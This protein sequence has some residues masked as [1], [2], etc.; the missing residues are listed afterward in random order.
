M[1]IQGQRC[2]KDEME[3]QNVFVRASGHLFYFLCLN[4]TPTLPCVARHLLKLCLYS[5]SLY[6]NIFTECI[7]ILQLSMPSTIFPQP[8]CTLCKSKGTLGPRYSHGPGPSPTGIITKT[9]S[10]CAFS[11]IKCS[12]FCACPALHLSNAPSLC[13]CSPLRL[14]VPAFNLCCCV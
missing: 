12:S 13:F 1:Y 2:L 4:P 5:S 3:Y 8:T 11:S 9:L 14:L 7:P 10:L 6:K